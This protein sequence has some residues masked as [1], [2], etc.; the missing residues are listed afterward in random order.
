LGQSKLETIKMKLIE[1]RNDIRTL[2]N[3][4]YSKIRKNE[5]LGPIFNGHIPD[6]KWEEHLSKLT[7]FWETNLFGVA[8]FKGNPTQ[9]HIAVDKNLNHTIEQEHFGMWLQL[10]FAT[11]DELF[12]GETADKAKNAARKMSTGQYISIWNRRPEHLKQL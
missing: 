3:T 7:D 9:K 12:E 1:N 6:D 2:V 4:F 11:I 5:L 10:W 8:N